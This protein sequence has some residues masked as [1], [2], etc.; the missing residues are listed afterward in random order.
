M[1]D[2]E[3]DGLRDLR[4]GLKEKLDGLKDAVRTLDRLLCRECD[5]TGRVPVCQPCPVCC[6]GPP[7]ILSDLRGPDAAGW[8]D[9]AVFV[10]THG[11]EGEPFVVL[12][13][14][15]SAGAKPFR[16]CD[17]KG[18]WWDYP[19][20][21]VRR[22]GR[23]RLEP[24]CIVMEGEAD[25]AAQV[26]TLRE[27]LEWAANHMDHSQDETGCCYRSCRSCKKIE[28]NPKWK[29]WLDDGHDPVID[30]LAATGPKPG[31]DGK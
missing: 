30:A 18:E 6:G 29:E 20:H 10:R 14:E 13:Y 4:M 2:A 11:S 22:L 9:V 31:E 25:L 12:D 24:A 8:S 3:R 27:A 1:T 16:L 28:A 15:P 26:A 19:F 21:D 5:G 7:M 23:G 17:T